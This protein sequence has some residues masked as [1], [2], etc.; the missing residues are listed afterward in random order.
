[1]L[2]SLLHSSSHENAV[3]RDSDDIIERRSSNHRG[4]Y[5][6]LNSVEIVL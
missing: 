4:R 2:G 5:A 1:M 6:F 3:E